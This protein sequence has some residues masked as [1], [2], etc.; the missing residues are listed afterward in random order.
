MC[1]R[2][3]EVSEACSRSRVLQI[4]LLFV[5][6]SRRTSMQCFTSSRVGPVG[7]RPELDRLVAVTTGGVNLWREGS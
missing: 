7:A 4:G 2:R 1:V 6:N 3:S 5:V